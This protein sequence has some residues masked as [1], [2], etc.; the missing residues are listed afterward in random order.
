M[1]N[2]MRTWAC[3]CVNQELAPILSRESLAAVDVALRF[4][5]GQASVAELGQAWATASTIARGLSKIAPREPSYF[6]AEAAAL[7]TLEDPIQA[8]LSVIDFTA[9]ALAA[10]KTAGRSV[11]QFEKAKQQERE[12]LRSLRF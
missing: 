12:R 6:A 2:E 7:T 8:K 11:H 10:R 5:S 4:A 1:L 9:S 3:K